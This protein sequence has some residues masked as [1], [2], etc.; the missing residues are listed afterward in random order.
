MEMVD[1]V[2]ARIWFS[3][4]KSRSANNYLQRPDL[5]LENAARYKKTEENQVP[6]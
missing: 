3:G 5:R 4:R 2:I 6:I 1:M